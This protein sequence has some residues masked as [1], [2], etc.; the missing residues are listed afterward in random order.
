MVALVIASAAAFLG[1]GLATTSAFKPMLFALFVFMVLHNI[2]ECDFLE[3]DGVLGRAAAGDRGA[4]QP[5]NRR[6]SL[7]GSRS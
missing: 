6:H 1:A 7:T 4:E 3:G 2:M 5:G